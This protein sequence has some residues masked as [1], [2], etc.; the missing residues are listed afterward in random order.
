MNR[1]DQKTK[2]SHTQILPVKKRAPS[3]LH[4]AATA[5]KIVENLEQ[6]AEAANK[7]IKIE[8]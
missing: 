5:S 7:M 2:I 1:E 3:F 4:N 8:K 6:F